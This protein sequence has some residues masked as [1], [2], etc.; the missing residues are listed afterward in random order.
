MVAWLSFWTL[1][2]MVFFEACTSPRAMLSPGHRKGW[3][4]RLLKSK[5]IKVEG[6]PVFQSRALVPFTVPSLYFCSKGKH[7]W[8]VEISKDFWRLKVI[9][10]YKKWHL[11]I[12]LQ[13]LK[14][15]FHI[16]DFNTLWKTVVQYIFFFIWE[17]I[18][19]KVLFTDK[20]TAF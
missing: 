16:R 12:Q 17:L 15:S 20:L 13:S 9:P 2:I 6:F 19:D 1:S 4:N 8:G 3:C 7:Q 10:S 14:H 11:P 5:D 18:N